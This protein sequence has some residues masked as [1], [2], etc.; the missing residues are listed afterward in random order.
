M[1]LGF[2]FLG[3]KIIMDLEA[4]QNRC[5]RLDQKNLLEFLRSSRFSA[6]IDGICLGIGFIFIVFGIVI[7]TILHTRDQT[8]NGLL[9]IIGGI[10]V[11]AIGGIM[12]VYQWARLPLASSQEL[13]EKRLRFFFRCNKCDRK[14]GHVLINIVNSM[15]GDIEETYECQECGE[16]KKIYELTS[17]VESARVPEPL[18]VTI[19]KKKK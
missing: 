19:K 17:T 7:P 9:A 1:Y 11:S 15:T 6:L 3:N 2:L 4:I 16:T 5:L 14:T 13:E 10:L 12:E 18:E 8:I